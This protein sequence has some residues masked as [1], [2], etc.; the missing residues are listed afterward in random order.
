MHEIN[1][2]SIRSNSPFNIETSK[3]S[4]RTIILS[5]P[6]NGHRENVAIQIKI[7]PFVKFETVFPNVVILL[8]HIQYL[9]EW[10]KGHNMQM[11]RG[12]GWI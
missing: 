5:L 7:S 12:E 1:I 4:L 10:G 6:K 3:N 11:I 9:S 8:V 2:I